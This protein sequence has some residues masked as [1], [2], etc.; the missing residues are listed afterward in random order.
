VTDGDHI[1]VLQ[2]MFLDQLAVD[3]G[4]V[5][6]VQVLKEGVIEDINNE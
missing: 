4:P 2:G 3:V 5:G 6:A 1:A